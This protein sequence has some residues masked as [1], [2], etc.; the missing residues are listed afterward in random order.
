MN[1]LITDGRTSNTAQVS[2]NRLATESVSQAQSQLATAEGN[3]YNINTGNVTLTNAVK[4]PLLWFK[5]TGD[6]DIIIDKIFYIMGASTGGSG[7]L[8]IETVRNPTTG[9][10][11]SNAS[12][13]GI[14]INRNFGSNNTINALA[15]KGATGNTMTDGTDALGTITVA[16]G[17]IVVDAGS[18]VLK[19]GSSLGVNFTPPA[20]NTS[21]TIQIALEVYERQF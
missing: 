10:I 5:N 13:V 16:N 15:Y 4:T 7:N 9:T 18:I 3:G 12:P 8:F 17:T 21:M 19:K 2:N 1:L 14:N 6:I 20:G 11:V